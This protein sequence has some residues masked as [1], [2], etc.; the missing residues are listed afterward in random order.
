MS[1]DIYYVEKIVDRKV[2]KG[3]PYFFIKWEGIYIKKEI[4]KI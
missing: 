3:K 1:D 2:V 4:Q